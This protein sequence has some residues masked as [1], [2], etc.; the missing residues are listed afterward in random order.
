[1]PWLKK[2]EPKLSLCKKILIF[3]SEFYTSNCLLN[4]R[5]CIVN[6][7][8][9]KKNGAKPDSYT[10]RPRDLLEKISNRRPFYQHKTILKWINLNKNDLFLVQIILSPAPI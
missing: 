2:H 5:S 1:M 3:D 4:S 7:C 9:L 8:F 6:S 10:Q